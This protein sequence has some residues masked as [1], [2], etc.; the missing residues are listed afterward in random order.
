MHIVDSHCH[1]DRLDLSP[2]K[3]LSDPLQAVLDEASDADVQ[4]MLCVGIDLSNAE[5]VKQIASQYS[6]VFASVGIHPCDV[7]DDVIAADTLKQL[8]D[9]DKVVAIGET[10]LDYYYSDESKLQQQ[11]S[12][13]SHLSVAK[14]MQLP[15]IVHTREAKADTL[16]IIAEHGCQN[17]SG[18]LHCFTEDL[19]MARSALD[20]GYYISFSGI[21]TFKN[22]QELK[23]VAKYVPTDRLLVETDSPYLTPVPFRGKAN[24]PKHTR[25]VLDY[26]AGLKKL[27]AEDLA[28]KTTDNFFRLFAK[29][30]LISGIKDSA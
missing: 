27:S 30:Q 23:D 17:S 10:G 5:T 24:Y 13:A 7:R 16:A 2:Y 22:A 3:H 4:H 15:V 12:F 6:Q 25:Q 1:L 26:V 11:Q 8:A 14:S 9:H 19:A 28:L 20:L 21:V 29:A 18:V